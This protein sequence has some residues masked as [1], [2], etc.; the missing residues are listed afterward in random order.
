[1]D[2]AAGGAVLAEPARVVHAGLP[3]YVA[4]LCKMHFKNQKE[5]HKTDLFLVQDQ[6]RA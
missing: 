2:E 5:R 3:K 1:V 4:L 6:R